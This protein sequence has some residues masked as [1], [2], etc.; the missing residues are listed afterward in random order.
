MFR[1]TGCKDTYFFWHLQ[2]TPNFLT[3]LLRTF[4]HF[5]SELFKIIVWGFSRD[6]NFSRLTIFLAVNKWTHPTVT[7]TMRT[8]CE[9]ERGE[10]SVLCSFYTHVHDDPEMV[11][12]MARR[13]ATIQPLN[14]LPMWGNWSWN[15]LGF[16]LCLS[17]AYVML[18][19]QLFTENLLFKRISLVI[20]IAQ[21]FIVE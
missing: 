10:F 19:V 16:M 9:R 1:K 5:H 7:S 3:F 8:T 4:W 18:L 13:C 12:R 17:Y 2:V 6:K 14:I 21:K 15:V 20:N 11:A